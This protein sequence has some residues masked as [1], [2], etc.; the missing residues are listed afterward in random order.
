MSKYYE[1]SRLLSKKDLNGKTP[2]IFIVAGNRTAGKTFSAKRTI[3]EDFLN[4]NKRKFM[5]QYRYNYELSDCENSF[6]SDIAQLYPPDFEM[7]AKSEM[8]GAYKVLY[9]NETECGFATFLNNADTIKKVSSRF[10]EVEN[11]LMDEFQSETEHYCENE[12][13]KFISIQNSIARGFGKQTRYVRN[14]LCGNNVS[15]LNPYYKALGIQK[16]LESDTKFLRGDGW[17]LEVTENQAAKEALLSSGFNRAFSESNYVQFASSNKYMLDTYSFVRKLE[18]KDKYYY[19]TITIN[20]GVLGTAENIGVWINKDCLYF[21]SKAN[22]KFKLKFAF[23]SNS[24]F[25]DTYLL[26]QL[27]ETAMA[28]KRYYN[29][30]K[31]WFENVDIKK[32]MLDILSYL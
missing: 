30:G 2:E 1:I 21:S 17:V 28:F 24:H 13:S 18:T 5:L 22:E 12:I 9:L 14:I 7:H 19:C 26:S 20:D 16:R 25:E 6:F 32:E 3:F 4:D 11:R 29:V 15:I 23:D 8:R 10:I 31:A 27:S